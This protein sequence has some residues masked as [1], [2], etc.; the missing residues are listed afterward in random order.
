MGDSIL[1]CLQLRL[2]II[3]FIFRVILRAKGRVRLGLRPKLGLEFKLGR[4]SVRVMAR[5]FDL[6]NHLLLLRR[7]QSLDSYIGE[8]FIHHVSNVVNVAFWGECNL[9]VELLLCAGRWSW[10]RIEIGSCS[11]F[12]FDSPSFEGLKVRQNRSLADDSIA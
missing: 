1:D 4:A 7:Q 10:S 12:G 3:R 9:H 2:Y 5:A 6:D 8:R 11:K